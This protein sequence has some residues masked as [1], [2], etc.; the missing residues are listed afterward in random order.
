M[1]TNQ[2]HFLTAVVIF[3]LIYDPAIQIDQETYSSA[4]VDLINKIDPSAITIDIP[5]PFSDND[6]TEDNI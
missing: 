1:E 6:E 2:V 4:I 5:S 3:S